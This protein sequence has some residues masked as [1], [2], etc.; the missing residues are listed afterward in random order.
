MVIQR[1][2]VAAAETRSFK[3]A[4]I[5]L[6]HVGGVEV[7]AKSIHRVTL[8]VGTELATC[9]DARPEGLVGKKIVTPPAVAIVECDGG[10]IRTR[11]PGHGP[12]VH[13]QGE[14]WRET[15]NACLIRATSQTFDTD[16]Q[17]NPPAC[18]LNQEHVARITEHA[19]FA[20]NSPETARSDSQDPACPAAEELATE[21]SDWVPQRLIRTVLSSMCNSEE[22][23]RLMRREADL[24][25]F[26]QA[27]RKAFL[28]DG[29]PWNWSIWKKHFPRY[30]P[31]LDFIHAVAYL[32]NAAVI[33]AGTPSGGWQL[34]QAWMTACWRGRIEDVIQE[35]RKW[36]TQVGTPSDSMPDDDPR[37][38]LAGIL[39]Y[40]ENNRKRMKYDA[41]RQQGLP[42]TTAWMES[43][44]KEV[45]YRVKGTEMFWNDP[46][47]AEAIL[48]IRAA[49]LSEDDRLVRYLATR[50]G[51]AYQR[52]TSAQSDLAA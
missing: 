23:G 25:Q 12:G 17:P 14:G 27:P 10:R 28:G 33:C 20:E 6:K 46:Q 51:C 43:L 26:H 11:E 3:R 21:S 22:F 24:R 8:D 13:G 44:V 34:Y 45:N 41:Y 19:L 16:P 4:A 30:V 2:V 39:A 5:V 49:A 38:L 37:V 48:Q 32:F 9:R 50:P 31:I 29:L 7:S 15:K 35:L 36:Q 52:R 42:V 47:G 1:L 18:F 40:L